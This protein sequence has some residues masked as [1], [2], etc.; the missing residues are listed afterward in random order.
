MGPLVSYDVRAIRILRYAQYSSKVDLKL[1]AMQ[2]EK[3]VAQFHLRPLCAAMQSLACNA[4]EREQNAWILRVRAAMAVQLT[5]PLL[6]K[7]EIC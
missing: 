6:F 1:V 5:V 7:A 4:R 3:S 2:L